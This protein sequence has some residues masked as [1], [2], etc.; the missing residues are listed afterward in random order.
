MNEFFVMVSVEILGHSRART[1]A[2][3]YSSSSNP[4]EQVVTGR[5]IRWPSWPRWTTNPRRRSGTRRAAHRSSGGRE[6]Q[7]KFVA[8]SLAPFLFGMLLDF[9]ERNIPVSAFRG[10]PRPRRRD[11]GRDAVSS[12]LVDGLRCGNVAERKIVGEGFVV[13]LARKN[14]LRQECISV[15]SRRRCGFSWRHRKSAFFLHDRAQAT[16]CA[17]ANPK[18][19]WQTCPRRRRK[20]S[21]PYSSY[22]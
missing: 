14:H 7:R 3:L 17:G 19:R 10:R 16:A 6:S 12:R 5:C 18:S 22:R 2:S 8:E 11:S 20:Q 13:R 4:M 21:S 1:A 9:G 15:Q